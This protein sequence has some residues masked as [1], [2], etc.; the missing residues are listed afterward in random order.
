MFYMPYT[1]TDHWYIKVSIC[2]SVW[3]WL[4]MVSGRGHLLYQVPHPF[5]LD[6]P[7][8]EAGTFCIQNRCSITKPQPLSSYG[9]IPHW[10]PPP[11]YL[12]FY[13]FFVFNSQVKSSKPQHKF[14]LSLLITNILMY[15]LSML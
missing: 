1:E 2:Y 14:K 15:T 6:L 9:I 4:S 10:V 13:Y 7:V 5:K 3:Q 12:H 11:P 8:T